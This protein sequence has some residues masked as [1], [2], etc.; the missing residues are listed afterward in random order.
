[1][2]SVTKYRESGRRVDGNM[3]YENKGSYERKVSNKC[4][5]RMERNKRWKWKIKKR[6]VNKL[7]K[8]E[9][10]SERRRKKEKKNRHR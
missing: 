9:R 10:E 8:R 4:M 5:G 1:M 7:H 3:N 2:P 6:K